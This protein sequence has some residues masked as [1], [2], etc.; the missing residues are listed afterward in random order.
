M[1]T[2]AVVTGARGRQRHRLPARRVA[3]PRRNDLSHAVSDTPATHPAEEQPY[4]QQNAGYS[5]LLAK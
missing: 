5:D 1:E 2:G 4:M 3:A